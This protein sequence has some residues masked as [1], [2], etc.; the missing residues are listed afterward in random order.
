MSYEKLKALGLGNN[1]SSL[2][3]SNPND[4]KTYMLSLQINT[5]IALYQMLETAPTDALY[6]IRELIDLILAKRPDAKR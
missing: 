3:A 6:K 1:L 5:N 2:I 4:P